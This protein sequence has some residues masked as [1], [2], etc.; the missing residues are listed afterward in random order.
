MEREGSGYDLLYEVLLSQGR[1]LPKLREGLD[2]ISVIIEKRIVK[3]EIIDFLTKADQTYSL[4]QREKILLGLLAQRESLSAREL[5][6]MLEL[7][8]TDETEIWIGRLLEWHLVRQTRRT[9]GTRYYV[10]PDLLRKLNFPAQ[11]SLARIESYRLDALVLEDLGRYPGSS[12]GEIH[13]RIGKEI[14][15]RQ[16]KVAL[17]RLCEKGELRAEGEKRWRKY[18]P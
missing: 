14:N 18:Y 7:G 6:G 12:I 9:R 5:V 11:T 13:E 8:D 1:Q 2:S 16:V 15:R 17:D 3:P 10:D 4:R